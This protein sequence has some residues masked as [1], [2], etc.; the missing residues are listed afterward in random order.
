LS[1]FEFLLPMSRETQLRATLDRLFFADTLTQRLEE[2]GSERLEVMLPK[3]PKETSDAHRS[4]FLSLISD[5]FG[6]YSISLVNGR[7]RAASLRT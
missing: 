5:W 4:R 6:G 3:Q 7:F 1:I 2:L